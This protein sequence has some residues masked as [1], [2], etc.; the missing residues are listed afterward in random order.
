MPKGWNRRSAVELAITVSVLMA[1]LLVYGRFVRW[2]EQRP[3]VVLPDPVLE[4]F[5]PRNLTWVIFVLIYAGL[6]TAILTLAWRAERLL[7]GLQSYA[8]MVLLRM[9]ALWL[10][11]L[12]PPQHMVPLVD[13]FVHVLG[14]GALLTNDLFFSGHTASLFVLYLVAPHGWPRNFLLMGTAVV[15]CCVLLQHIHYSID[16]LGALVFAPAAVKLASTLRARFGLVL[17]ADSAPFR[18]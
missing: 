8:A 4:L 12:E 18:G 6:F 14:P 17:A 10:V 9:V 16:V 1:V 15:A 2:V 7:F 5:A 3:G 13:P 11:P